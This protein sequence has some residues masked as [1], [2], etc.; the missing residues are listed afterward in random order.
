MSAQVIALADV[1]AQD[2]DRDV[3]ARHL[4]AVM[5][6]AQLGKELD[7]TVRTL[8]RWR[9]AG[10]GPDYQNPKGTRFYRYYGSDV[11]AWLENRKPGAATPGQDTN[12]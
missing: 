9:V 11:E 12:L 4:P 6:P 7:V 3:A 1:R 2:P 10:E 5:S 8:E